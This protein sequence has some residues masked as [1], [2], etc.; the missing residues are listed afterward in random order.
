VFFLLGAR[1]SSRFKVSS[2]PLVICAGEPLRE[3]RKQSGQVL[4]TT[5]RTGDSSSG[6]APG[7]GGTADLWPRAS[8]GALGGQ[9][10]ADWECTDRGGD[11]AEEREVRVLVGG[12]GLVGLRRRGRVLREAF[13]QV[14]D[15]R[16]AE[17]EGR[18]GI[19]VVAVEG[20]GW[21]EVSVGAV[22]CLSANSLS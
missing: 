3:T 7:E 15:Q 1:P 5:D 13:V 22:L 11:F 14:T 12:G 16:R 18:T 6:H 10:L 20:P 21:V 19:A 2:V 4:Q 17:T 8:A 9:G